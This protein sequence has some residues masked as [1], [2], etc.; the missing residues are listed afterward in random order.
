MTLRDV[1]YVLEKTPYEKKLELAQ[2]C[3][4]EA[5]KV[6]KR[7]CVAFS[8]GKNSLVVL[9]MVIRKKPDV[10]VLFNN[11]TNELAETL[12]YVRWLAKEWN[13]NF[14]EV[15]PDTNYWEVVE[16]YGFPHHNR[17]YNK[18]P[19][20]CLLLKKKPAEKFYRKKRVDC[21]FL[22]ISAAESRVRK[23]WAAKEGMLYRGKERLHAYP[24]MFWTDEDVWKYIREHDLPAN[25]AYEK[26]GID[27]IGC[28]ACTGFIGWQ[29]K[30]QKVNPRLYE[31]VMRKMGQSLLVKEADG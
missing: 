18:E 5:L 20:C 1:E 19:K 31:Y 28:V 2:F 14:Y 23:V 26:Y 27:R 17:Y 13:L 16:K 22:G 4:D 25:P 9:H 24:L 15:K 29:E 6:S 8:G 11:T 10:L 30:M 7:P 12:K 21:V 3:V